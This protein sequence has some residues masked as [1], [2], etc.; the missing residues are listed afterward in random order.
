[1]GATPRRTLLLLAILTLRCNNFIK[2]CGRTVQSECKS[3]L[4][5]AFISERGHWQER[6]RYSVHPREVG[7]NPERGNRYA[8]FFDSSGDV[9]ERA[10]VDAGV[11]AEATGIGVDVLK[12]RRG[13]VDRAELP[14]RFVGNVRL[15]ITGDCAGGGD[16][17]QPPPGCFF[18]AACA[19]RVEETGALAIWS[20]ATVDRTAPDGEVVLAGQ[21]F[22]ETEDEQR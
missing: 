16:M 6:D 14:T 12:H 11:S 20:V 10:T 18:V 4:K 1:M 2:V 8:Y 22:M 17:N 3:N 21:P 19:R 9:A 15:G 7:F 5:S 13:R